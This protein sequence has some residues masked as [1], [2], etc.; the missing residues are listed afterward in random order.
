MDVFTLYTLS[1]WCFRE[2]LLRLLDDKHF[3]EEIVHFNISE[4]GEVVDALHRKTL[5]PLLMRS[6]RL[7]VCLPVC[8]FLF[9]PLTIR[10]VCLSACLSVCLLFSF[11]STCLFVDDVFHSGSNIKIKPVDLSDL[12]CIFQHYV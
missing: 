4:E 12:S 9:L 6:V 5:I 10:S 7:S 3:K 8:L 11:S 1:W 2:N